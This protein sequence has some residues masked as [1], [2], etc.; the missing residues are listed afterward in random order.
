MIKYQGNYAYGER[1]ELVVNNIIK[2]LNPSSD[3][4]ENLVDQGK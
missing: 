4:L 1:H 3:I 2:L